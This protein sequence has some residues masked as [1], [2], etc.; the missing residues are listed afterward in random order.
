MEYFGTTCTSAGHYRWEITAGLSGG[1][2]NTSD[3]PF[4]PEGVTGNHQRNGS[5]NFFQGGGY[6]AIAIVGSPV[7]KRAGS[8]SVFWVKEI[9]SKEE[10][11]Q[12]VKQN[13]VAAKIVAAMPFEVNW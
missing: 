13:A 2:L 10:M 6:T 7:D 8:K 11:I 12:R 3:L 5:V 9:I 4:N 1:G